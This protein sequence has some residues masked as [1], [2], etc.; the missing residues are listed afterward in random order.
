M[1]LTNKIILK[2]VKKIKIKKINNTSKNI[3]EK[4]KLF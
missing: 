3:M 4:I 2:R 1:F